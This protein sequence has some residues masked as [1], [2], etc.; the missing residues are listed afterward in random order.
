MDEYPRDLDA[1]HSLIGTYQSPINARARGTTATVS[2]TPATT[3]E[4]SA[5]TFAKQGATAGTN[6]VV[7]NDITC[8]NCQCIGHYASYCP[9]DSSATIGTTLTQY[10]YMLAQSNDTGIDPNWILLDSQ[11]TI[12]VLKNASM[13]SD[14]HLRGHT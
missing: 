11:S 6:G 12:S 14:I 13:L 1:A 3:P 10:A 2:P 5:I 7:H 4:V 8:Y 9:Q